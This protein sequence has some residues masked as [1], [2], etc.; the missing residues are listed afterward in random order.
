MQT[1][2]RASSCGRTGACKGLDLLSLEVLT[3]VHAGAG[4]LETE[5]GLPQG[6]SGKQTF[7]VRKDLVPSHAMMKLVG[8]E[9]LFPR[10]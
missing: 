7:R 6:A 9:L 1:G 8:S 3:G 2:S 10:G 5:L 4:G